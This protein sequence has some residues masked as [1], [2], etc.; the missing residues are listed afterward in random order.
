MQAYYAYPAT[1]RATTSTF[2]E[3]KYKL[4]IGSLQLKRFI[5]LLVLFTF[6]ISV[7]S[8]VRVYANTTIESSS[9]SND[10][11]LMKV[12]IQTGDTLWGIAS[13]H[14]PENVSIQAFVHKL[15]KLNQ[16][17]GSSIQVGQQLVIPIQS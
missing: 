2:K 13:Q 10:A 1:S 7:G 9:L 3:K 5:V 15:K 16:L 11:N 4:T 14:A 8:M 12:Y 6:C 17:K